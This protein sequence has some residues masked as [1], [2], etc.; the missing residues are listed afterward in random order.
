MATVSWAFRTVPKMIYKW[1]LIKFIEC[2]VL[3]FG[4]FQKV[5]AI[6]TSTEL[7]LWLIQKP[8]DRNGLKTCVNLIHPM[9]SF[10]HL[11]CCPICYA[12]RRNHRSSYILTFIKWM[13][14]FTF[15]EWLAFHIYLCCY[16]RGI[17]NQHSDLSQISKTY[18]HIEF[19]EIYS[20]GAQYIS[21]TSIMVWKIVFT[22]Q[23]Y[24]RNHNWS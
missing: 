6:A 14:R 7:A 20:K 9:C 16:R 19:E 2:D 23:T 12:L 17:E 4:I 3:I 11:Y 10:I 5:D 18:S 21:K 1:S 8:M 15:I 13:Y 22:I 24:R